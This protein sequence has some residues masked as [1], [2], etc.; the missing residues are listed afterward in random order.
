[1]GRFQQSS[2]RVSVGVRDW[3]ML[4]NEMCLARFTHSS[5][6]LLYRLYIS[7]FFNFVVDMSTDDD[8]YVISLMALS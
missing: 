8:T 1:M 6:G 2:V 4:K 3:S 5:D 7:L